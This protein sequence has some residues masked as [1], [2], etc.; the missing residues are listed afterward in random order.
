LSKIPWGADAG[1]VPWGRC[2]SECNSGRTQ[3]WVGD[4]SS[5]LFTKGG[6]K[7]EY[8]IRG[9]DYLLGDVAA[10]GEKKVPLK[11]KRSIVNECR[12]VLFLFDT[13]S[14]QRSRGRALD[15]LSLFSQAGNSDNWRG[16]RGPEKERPF[17]G[18]SLKIELSISTTGRER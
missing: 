13:G 17:E 5:R 14:A 11:N 4:R 6:L 9:A 1:R 18:K 8:V 2:R 12:G 15:S 7:G 10:V 16:W 3:S